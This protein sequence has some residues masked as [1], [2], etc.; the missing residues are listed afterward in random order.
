MEWNWV[1]L[2]NDGLVARTCRL[3]VAKDGQRLDPGAD[4]ESQKGVFRW[5]L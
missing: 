1:S 2:G 5:R 3:T 4:A